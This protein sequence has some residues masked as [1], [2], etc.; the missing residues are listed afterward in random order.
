M[1][2]ARAEPEPRRLR[3]DAGRWLKQQRQ[4]AGLSQVQLSLSSLRVRAERNGKV[5][6]FRSGAPVSPTA[7]PTVPRGRVE[8]GA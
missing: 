5:V 8:A 2:F 7:N 1:Y 4:A 6:T 3:K